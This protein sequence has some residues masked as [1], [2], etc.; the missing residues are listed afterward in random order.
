MLSFLAETKIFV[1]NFESL[2][3]I[4]QSLCNY[5]CALGSYSLCV[6]LSGVF[7]VP[8]A[9]VTWMRKAKGGILS[10]KFLGLYSAFNVSTRVHTFFNKI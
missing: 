9:G 1:N 10:F 4:E 7:V 5:T 8:V 3:L 6:C 2:L